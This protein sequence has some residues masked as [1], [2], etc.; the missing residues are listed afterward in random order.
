MFTGKC[1]SFVAEPLQQAVVWPSYHQPPS[2]LLPPLPPPPLQLLSSSS[3]EY[4]SSNTTVHQH[5]QTQSTRLLALATDNK[6]KIPLPIPTTLIK[7]ETDSASVSQGRSFQSINTLASNTAAVFTDT[8][9]T[10]LLTTHVIYQH[11]SS[12]ILSQ[13]AAQSEA[14]CRSQATSPVTCLTPPPE[15]VPPEDES[16]GVQDAGNQTENLVPSEEEISNMEAKKTDLEPEVTQKIEIEVQTEEVLPLKPDIS[17]LELLSNSIVEYENNCDNNIKL[18]LEKTANEDK[19]FVNSSLINDNL[20]GLDLLCALAEQRILEE[21]DEIT[22]TEI[23]ENHPKE[24]VQE[25]RKHKKHSTKLEPK[26][27]KIKK[28]QL[29]LDSA[30]IPRSYKTPESKEEVKKF[31]AS[32]SQINSSE[33]WPQMDEMELDMRMKLAD[34]QRQYREKQRELSR[35]KPRKLECLKKKQRK[36]S[37]YSDDSGNVIEESVTAQEEILD[38]QPEKPSQCLPQIVA[39]IHEKKSSKKRKVGR[40]KKLLY[41]LSGYHEATETIVAKKPKSNIVGYLLAAKEKFQLQCKIYSN[42]PPKYTDDFTNFQS[43]N[44]NDNNNSIDITP[45]KDEEEN[46]YLEEVEEVT[47][48]KPREEL[49]MLEEQPIIKKEPSDTKCVL[50][51]TLLEVDKLR[52]LTAMGGLFYAGHLNA[53]EPPDLYSITLDGERGN[54]PHIM[55]REDILRDT[56]SF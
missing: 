23:I 24:V 15:I 44:D 33:E 1:L 8:S 7:I 30:E 38:S 14:M 20:G 4:L 3:S 48:I 42:S 46:T 36:K 11:P 28:D 9:I 47:D 25:K 39:E 22:K 37:T 13:A 12:I 21:N 45:S 5:T 17:G 40:P 35:L 19:E 6:R 52:V 27:K 34:L 56:V 29:C 26:Q 50:T 18:S 31:I 10:P 51:T 53:V 32:K 16:L 2:V 49:E 41:S 43:V 55:C 54:R